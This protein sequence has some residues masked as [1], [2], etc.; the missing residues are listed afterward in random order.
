MMHAFDVLADPVRRRILEIL[1]QGEHTSGEVVE[2]VSKDF[3]IGQSAV[4]QHLKVLRD[5]GFA[6]ERLMRWCDKNNVGY[7]FGYQKNNVL[8]KQIA[9]E[10]TRARIEQ[11]CYGAKQ[12]CFKWFRYRAEGWDRHRWM[13]GKAEYSSQAETLPLSSVKTITS[14]LAVPSA[15]STLRESM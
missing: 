11:S 10:M 15:R 9:C 2:I 4:S 5:S 13:I 6:N 1:G 7:V 14:R 8:I 3:S 12:S